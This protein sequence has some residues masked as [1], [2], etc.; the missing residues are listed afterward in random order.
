[1]KKHPRKLALH[2]ETIR[3]LE[4]SETQRVAGA[5]ANCTSVVCV[6][7]TGCC[8]SQGNTDCYPRTFCLGSCSCSAY[9]CD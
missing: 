7:V 4:G 1:M 9:P 5:S 8:G 2:R 3:G 6:E